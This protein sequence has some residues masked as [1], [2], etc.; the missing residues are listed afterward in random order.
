MAS[1][2]SGKISLSKLGSG[3]STNFTKSA[4]LGGILGSLL[5]FLGVETK[6]TL[7]PAL[8]KSMES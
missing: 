5:V 7:I 4:R 1:P 8:A 2:S 6:E 3:N